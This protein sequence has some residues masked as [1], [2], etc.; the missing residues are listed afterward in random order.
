MAM[1]RWIVV[2]G[3]I[4]AL[5]TA[6]AQSS[7]SLYARR[8]AGEVWLRWQPHTAADMRSGMRNGYFLQRTTVKK[9]GKVLDTDETYR[10][11]ERPLLVAGDSVVG[12]LVRVSPEA[13][14]V[15]GCLAED[16]AGSGRVSDIMLK[17]KVDELC[18]LQSQVLLMSRYDLA[19]YAGLGMLDKTAQP[20]EDYLY[21]LISADS[22]KVL[23]SVWC[24]VNNSMLPLPAP[25]LIAT[26]S[27]CMLSVEAGVPEFFG[28]R[29]ER[30]TGES[31]DFA[32]VSPLPFLPVDIGNGRWSVR[33]S[34][35]ISGGAEV[36]YRVCGLDVFGFAGPW[37]DTIVCV[38]HMPVKIELQV[39]GDTFLT[40]AVTGKTGLIREWQ[41]EFADSLNG[42]YQSLMGAQILIGRQRV[43]TPEISGYVRLKAELLNGAHVFSNPVLIQL[44][45]SIP[46]EPPLIITGRI[47]STGLVKLAWRPG[48]G[49]AASY[50]A[51]YRAGRRSHEPTAM[52]GGYRTDSVLTDTISLPVV[53]DSVY[54]FITAL[55]AR[56]NES[57]P[58]VFALSVPDVIPPPRPVF[59]PWEMTGSGYVVH[60]K[61]MTSHNVV[62]YTLKRTSLSDSSVLIYAINAEKKSV[63][64]FR[65]SIGVP[66]QF[67][68]YELLATDV[69]GNRSE[70]SN[71]LRL[72]FPELRLPAVQPPLV[73]N[74]SARN[75]IVLMWEYPEIKNLSHFRI[76]MRE[77]DGNTITLGT[78]A[79]GERQFIIQRRFND[80]QSRFIIRA[81][82]TDGKKSP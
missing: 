34:D 51:V 23:T 64:S 5:Q 28:Y 18:F 68:D 36:H 8:V 62:R 27:G 12:S 81:Y 25:E 61:D 58:V 77:P 41:A 20:D 60:W 65:D 10:L 14:L 59:S 46:P 37:S 24:G 19:L 78:C 3:M 35:S 56:Y 76:M 63:T 67:Y 9:Q 66:G 40:W 43:K 55:D 45:D 30:A 82:T 71:P 22:G 26:E 70:W 72:R 69:S 54:Y 33:Y 15:F 75:R 13:A 17:Q 50:Y 74:D 47:D 16:S 7:H 32:P 42:A 44:K 53:R 1:M 11:N 80:N 21:T 73:L 48:P 79:A 38:P 29:I 52:P 4:S 57:Q 6:T 39:S 49:E 31:G 2:F